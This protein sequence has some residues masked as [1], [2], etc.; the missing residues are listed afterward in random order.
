MPATAIDEACISF[1]GQPE[2]AHKTTR[3]FVSVSRFVMVC[4]KS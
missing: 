3:V 2:I 4:E 1:V